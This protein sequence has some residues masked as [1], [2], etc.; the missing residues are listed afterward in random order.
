M[1][2]TFFGSASA[3][4]HTVETTSCWRRIGVWGQERPR[5]VEL[6]RVVHCRNC[7]VFAQAAQAVFTRRAEDSPDPVE[8]STPTAVERAKGDAACLPFRIGSLWLALPAA[9]VVAIADRMPLHSIPHRRDGVVLG[10]APINGEIVV[11]ISLV[12]LLGQNGS[13]LT[14]AAA[15]NRG[16]YARRVVVS[17]RARRVAFDVDEV[18]GVQRF[19]RVQLS[20]PKRVFDPILAAQLEGAIGLDDRAGA[21]IGVIDLRAFLG[22]LDRVLV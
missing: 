2:E 5:C 9:S 18:R 14:N 7:E 12:G 22:A 3:M 8:P 17:A 21:M 13:D 10:L 4:V 20:D 16:V 11:A 1:P 6:E 15:L 19:F